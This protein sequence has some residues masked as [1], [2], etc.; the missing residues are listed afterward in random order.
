MPELQDYIQIIPNALP[1]KFCEGITRSKGYR[2]E[3]A[4]L[5]D[6]ESAE[7]KDNS[8]RNCEHTGLS[9]EDDAVVFGAVSR[10]VNQYMEGYRF[11]IESKQI[12]D[13]GY[14]LLRYKEGG[15]YRQHIDDNKGVERR[16]SMSLLLNDDYDGGDFQ[17]FGDYK[18]NCEA[19][20]AIVFP[21]NYCFPHEILEVQS[22]ERYSIVTW[23]F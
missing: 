2:Y 1:P 7:Y 14:N 13:T 6:L 12:N 20:S 18:V 19:G 16:I 10:V 4:T 21:S 3:Q 17:F 8:Y 5:L 11:V 9:R 23:V 15:F 22:G